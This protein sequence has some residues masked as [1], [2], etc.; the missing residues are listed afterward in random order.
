MG[1]A[2]SIEVEKMAVVPA[3]RMSRCIKERKC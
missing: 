2:I 1:K 3:G